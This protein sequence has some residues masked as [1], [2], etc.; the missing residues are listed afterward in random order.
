ML[1]AKTGGQLTRVAKFTGF[2]CII[3][4]SCGGLSPG[5]CVIG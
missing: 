2:Y 4:I 1:P 5:T 3:K